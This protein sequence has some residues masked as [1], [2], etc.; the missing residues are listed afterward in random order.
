MQLQIPIP[1]PIAIST[2]RTSKTTWLETSLPGVPYIK[3]LSVTSRC[4]SLNHG[5]RSGEPNFEAMNLTPDWLAIKENNSCTVIHTIFFPSFHIVPFK[6]K[7]GFHW[8]R[9]R[10]RCRNQ[11]PRAIRCSENQTD[12]VGSRTLIPLMT[13]SLTISWKLDCQS[14]KRKRKN[15]P[16]VFVELPACC[17]SNC[18]RRTWGLALW[19]VYSSASASDSD[20][21]VFTGS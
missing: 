21:L 12:R 9:S 17:L 2:T 16:M 10:S 18:T 11:K 6:I 20:N 5:G 13:P 15:K 3:A 8:R 1:I 7:A 4:S 19:L 14:L